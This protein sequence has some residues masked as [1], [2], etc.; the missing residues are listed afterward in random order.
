MSAK[1]DELAELK[2]QLRLKLCLKAS[3]QFAV[4]AQAATQNEQLCLVMVASAAMCA[5]WLGHPM[6]IC[7]KMKA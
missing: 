4:S 7:V 6:F 3:T 2:R 5:L 1:D